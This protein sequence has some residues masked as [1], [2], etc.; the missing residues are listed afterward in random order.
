M[1]KS[2][3]DYRRYLLE[4]YKA[5]NFSKKTGIKSW[6]I[7]ALKSMTKGNSIILFLESLRKLEY[8]TNCKPLYLRHF[9]HLIAHINYL[10]WSQINGFSIPINTFGPGLSIAHRGTIVVNSGARIGSNCRIHVCVNIGTAKGFGTAAPKIG[11]NVYIGPGAKLFGPIEI[12][13]DCIIGANAVVNKT[14]SIKG[15]K[16][17]GVPAKIHF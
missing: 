12:A 2:K 3:D 17:L 6:F 15:A 11:N 16:L 9:R 5:N 1:I 14:C 8:L 10:R 13:D 7:K 4:D